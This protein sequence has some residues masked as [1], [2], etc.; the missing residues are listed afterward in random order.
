MICLDASKARLCVSYD[1]GLRTVRY[2]ATMQ[3]YFEVHYSRGCD[4]PIYHN[5]Q[6]RGEPLTALPYRDVSA[7]CG[8]PRQGDP[9]RE[10]NPLPSAYTLDRACLLSTPPFPERS[11][12][13]KCIDEVAR[14]KRSMLG[15]AS[16]P[17][18]SLGFSLL[19]VGPFAIHVCCLVTNPQNFVAA[20][21]EVSS[22]GVDAL[23]LGHQQKQAR[24]GL[25]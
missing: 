3:R 15:F 2:R 8:N 7:T 9:L 24:S 25:T 11:P 5:S 19:Y 14:P 13:I 20:W 12:R 18:P 4:A 21:S 1:T 16:T 22:K 6:G 10:R 17:R 23:R